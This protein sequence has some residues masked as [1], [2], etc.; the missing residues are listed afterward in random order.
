LDNLT[1]TDI[2]KFV[3]KEGKK[4]QRTLSILGKNEQLLNAIQTP[5]GQ[6]LLSDAL[7]NI[8]CL[9]EKIIDEKADEKDRAD[10]RALRTLTIRWTEKIH[11]YQEALMKV[12][13]V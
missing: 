8:D 12:K 5:I 9:L 10:Y 13:N 4:A 11:A 2:E 7:Q 1:P 3:A 6:E